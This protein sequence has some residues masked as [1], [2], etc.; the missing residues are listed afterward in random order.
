MNEIL[1]AIE[2]V[3]EERKEIAFADKV[4]YS[5]KFITYMY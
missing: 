1:L 5:K 2:V 4:K 3:H